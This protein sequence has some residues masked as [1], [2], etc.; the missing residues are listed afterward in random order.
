MKTKR[1]IAM[2]L[3]MSMLLALLVGCGKK[4]DEKPENTPELTPRPQYELTDA[5]VNKEE[6]VYINVSPDGEEIGR[7]SCRERV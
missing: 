6:T 3:A 4:N 7:A 2:L 5:A 1:L